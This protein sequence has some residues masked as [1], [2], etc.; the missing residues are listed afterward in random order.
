MSNG[1]FVDVFKM[2]TCLCTHNRNAS[3]ENLQFLSVEQSI[4]DVAHLIVE[5]KANLTGAEESKVILWGTGL[6]ASLATWT[7]QKF[8]HLVNAV[9]SSSGVYRHLV[10]SAGA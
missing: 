3:F 2:R 6:G 1:M 5:V 4:S 7:K 10:H 9:W 8:P